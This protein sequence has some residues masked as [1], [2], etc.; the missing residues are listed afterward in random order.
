MR[1]I[2]GIEDHR[3]LA[4]RERQR[5]VQR[6]SA[7][8]RNIHIIPSIRGLPLFGTRLSH[9][10]SHDVLFLTVRNNLSRRSYRL[11]KRAFDVIAAPL[12]LVLLTP[13]MLV[14]SLLIRADG[15]SAIYGHTRIG[16][17]GERFKCLKFRSMKLNAEKTLQDLLQNDP[18]AR[19]EWET[20]FKLKSDPRITPVGHFL[21]STSLDELPQLV[22]VIKGEMS[23]VGPRPIVE[24]E[25]DRYGEQASL[26][27]QVT[28]GITGLWQ[29]SGR[30][31]TTYEERVALDTWYV[32]NWS[33]WYDVAILFS[34]VGVVLQRKGAY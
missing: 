27:L 29:I 30:N 16:R 25:L 19:A 21:R 13:L 8:A 20:H 12:L 26:Y 14:L 10:F 17:G 31:N 33:L 28:P 1:Q 7:I 3:V 34:T 11:L 23:L 9:F 6:L 4:A 32:Q 5:V 2:F 18:G 15:G 24:E 22:N